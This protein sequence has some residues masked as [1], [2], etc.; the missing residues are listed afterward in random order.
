M[1]HKDN[2]NMNMMM[3]RFRN[4][5]KFLKDLEYAIADERAAIIFYKELY[6]ITPT[7]IAKNSIKK[8]LDDEI[9]HDKSLT[10][11]YKRLTGK[12]PMVKVKRI[13]FHHFYDGLQTAFLD[14]VKAYKFYKRMYLSTNCPA[15]RDLMYSIQHDEMEHATL[16]NWVHSELR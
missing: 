8:A 5:P 9:L 6:K 2:P 12:D 1:Y 13:E 14:E 4:Y 10:H 15:I 7:K 3:R 16:F 11:L